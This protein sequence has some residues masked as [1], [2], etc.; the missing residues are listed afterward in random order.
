MLT[1][2]RH[3]YLILVLC[4]LVLQACSGGESSNGN[5][6]RQ[7]IPAVEAVQAGEG[8]LPLVERLSGLVRAQNQVEIYPEVSAVITTVHVN[9]GDEVKKGS[10]L[11]SLRDKEFQERLNQSRAALRIAEAQARQSEAELKEMESEYRRAQSLAEKDLINDAE[12]ES[13]ETEVLSARADVDLAHARVEQA[14]ATVAEREEHLAQTVI[15]APISGSVGNRNAEIGMA[16][17]SSTRLFT[18]G[19]LDTV[20]VE[21]VLTDRMLSYIETEQRAAILSPNLPSG[22]ATAKLSRISPFLH[23]V[24]HSTEAEID[25]P[26]PNHALKSGMFVTTDIYYGESESATLIPLS[27]LYNNPQTGETGIYLAKDT[28][29]RLN[30]E[31]AGAGERNQLTEPVPFVFT[32]VEVIA[33]GR[34][35]VGVRGIQPGDWIV[36]IGQDLLAGEDGEARVRPVSRAWVEHL[37]NLQR[38]DL[39][40]EI[41]QSQKA[42]QNSV[43]TLSAGS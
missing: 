26:N 32:P 33:K 9:N 43:D 27:A 42:R 21:V 7:L 38:E 30:S 11:V 40:E 10:P 41:V 20:R 17:S 22:E 14:A 36:T 1:I 34:M 19:Q 2:P 39:L 37:Q 6:R 8:A 31:S 24:T 4:C 13:A 25:L 16:V 28:L 3:A 35:S 18:L 23:P 29:S 12:L 15:R 5:G